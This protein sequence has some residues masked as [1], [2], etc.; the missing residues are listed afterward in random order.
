MA[1]HTGASPSGSGESRFPWDFLRHKQLPGPGRTSLRHQ[2]ARVRPQA[3]SRP[4][5]G[6]GGPCGN[7][8]TGPRDSSRAGEQV[9]VQKEGKG[10]DAPWRR[11]AP[12]ALPAWSRDGG[13]KDAHILIPATGIRWASC[14]RIKAAHRPT[15]GQGGH[16]G[17]SRRAQGS[18]RVLARRRKKGGGRGTPARRALPTL[19]GGSR[20]R[21]AGLR[22]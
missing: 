22:G 11:R 12:P 20:G 15:L 3:R 14:R 1:A 9:A 19:A 18:H 2:R 5:P 6:Q 8:A 7:V 4:S 10:D 21:G 13:R 17:W 16:P